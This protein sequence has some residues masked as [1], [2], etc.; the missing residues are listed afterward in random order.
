MSRG[1]ESTGRF[2]SPRRLLAA[3]PGLELVPLPEADWCCGAA[4]SY[5]MHQPAMAGRVLAR[6]MGHIAA[7]E[8]PIVATAN[9]GCMLQIRLGAKRQRL[10][11]I[12]VHPVQL[13]ARACE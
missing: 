2:L 5:S 3:I 8:V 10:Q 4:G 1:R 12:V 7:T 6:K 9:P 13:L 11:L